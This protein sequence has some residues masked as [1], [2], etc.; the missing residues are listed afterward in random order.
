M[1]YTG[2]HEFPGFNPCGAGV[3][4]TGGGGWWAGDGRQKHLRLE[5]VLVGKGE[6][7]PDSEGRHACWRNFLLPAGMDPLQYR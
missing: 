2:S 1:V 7:Q 5:W 4:G 6:Q 3:V